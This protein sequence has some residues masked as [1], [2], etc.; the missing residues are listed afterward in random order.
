MPRAVATRVL[1]ALEQEVIIH[2]PEDFATY[3]VPTRIA[4]VDVVDIGCAVG[5]VA[6]VLQR[7]WGHRRNVGARVVDYIMVSLVIAAKVLGPVVPVGNQVSL[8]ATRKREAHVCLGGCALDLLLALL[9]L[10]LFVAL[11]VLG[12]APR[13]PSRLTTLQVGLGGMCIYTLRQKGIRREYCGVRGA[14]V[15]EVG[16]TDIEETKLQTPVLRIYEAS[17]VPCPQLRPT[18][19]ARSQCASRGKVVTIGRRY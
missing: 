2:V 19:V 1:V 8:R 16:A 7:G 9:V 3:N 14:N 15:E 17:V 12:R 10:F 11:G 4:G 18:I 6:N 13:C 5:I